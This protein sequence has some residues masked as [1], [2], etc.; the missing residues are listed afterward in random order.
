MS[1]EHNVQLDDKLSNSQL[2]MF[3]R[4]TENAS[5]I[6]P[7]CTASTSKLKS[8]LGRH[9]ER[10]AL[11]ALPRHSDNKND[12]NENDSNE[13]DSVVNNVSRGSVNKSQNAD[14][15]SWDDSSSHGNVDQKEVMFSADGERQ[16]SSN[17]EYNDMVQD[18][19]PEIPAISWDYVTPNFEDTAV[20]QGQ[21][22]G[23]N[24]LYDGG[25]DASVDIVFVHGL[26]G[27]AYNAW[28]YK[29]KGVMVHWP[30]ELLKQDLPDARIM[31][32]GYDADIV[33]LWNPRSHSPLTGHAETMVG[34]L[35]RKRERTNTED[36]KI[37]FVGHSLG[38]LVIEH[39]LSHSRK[40][41][42]KF[43]R[44]IEKFTVGIVFLGVPHCGADLGAW[45]SFGTQ[46]ANIVKRPNQDLLGVL[47]PGSEML[48]LVENDFHKIL[49]LRKDEESEISITCFY[50]ELD[51]RP[52][53]QV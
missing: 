7:L 34:A 8:H 52:I 51:V 53:G 22:Y 10:I 41:V 49:R 20:R 32:Y 38:G 15:S 27:N 39:A 48:H 19:V 23:I 45:E 31:S 46:L 26:T 47:K 50:E 13:N 44:K 24:V 21:D 25:V 1:A 42:E 4:P 11:F 2:S 29:D 5:G 35:L 33:N 43:L 16:G 37:L 40:S 14:I 12:S 18:I 9:L 28:L 36:R 3:L 6:C 30:S 17:A